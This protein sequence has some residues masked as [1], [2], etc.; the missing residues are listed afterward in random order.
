[1]NTE[2]LFSPYQCNARWEQ[3]NWNP[4]LTKC[5]R[6][7][8]L[9]KNQLY[10]VYCEAH[11]GENLWMVGGLAKRLGVQPCTL[12]WVMNLEIWIQNSL[13]YFLYVIRYTCEGTFRIFQ[14]KIF[15]LLQK[16]IRR[17]GVPHWNSNFE[18]L[19]FGG[20][21]TSREAE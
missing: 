13:H 20:C 14:K 16:C 4:L 12:G 15:L 5:I 7:V 2:A 21:Y 9:N 1:M 11:L 3:A 8:T 18:V 19:N 10:V 6:N 17:F